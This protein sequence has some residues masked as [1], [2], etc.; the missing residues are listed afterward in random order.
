MLINRIY[1]S[2]NQNQMKLIHLRKSS[3]ARIMCE[4][5]AVILQAICSCWESITASMHVKCTWG[6]RTQPLLT[7]QHLFFNNRCLR[8]K[9]NLTISCN[10]YCTF[11][12]CH[13]IH[14]L[15]KNSNGYIAKLKLTRK[16]WPTWQKGLRIIAF[17]LV[18]ALCY[19]VVRRALLHTV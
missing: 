5:C 3:L 10:D 13:T 7:L 2:W 18:F 9:V 17:K 4:I 15:F 14:I 12:K 8:A 1:W 6:K 19:Q 11:E 16:A